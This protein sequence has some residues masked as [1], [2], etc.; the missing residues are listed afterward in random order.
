[1]RRGDLNPCQPQAF[2]QVATQANLGHD[3]ILNGI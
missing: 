3:L 2:G 1:M